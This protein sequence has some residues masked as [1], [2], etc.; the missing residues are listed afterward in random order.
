[1]MMVENGYFVNYASFSKIETALESK[2]L[3]TERGAPRKIIT[4]KIVRLCSVT[5]TTTLQLLPPDGC[6]YRC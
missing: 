4:L 1:M 5:S 3:A 6:F 2:Q